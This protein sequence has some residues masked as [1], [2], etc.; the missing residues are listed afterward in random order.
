MTLCSATLVAVGSVNPNT[1]KSEILQSN[2][3]TEIEDV[4]AEG[5]FNQY[6]VVFYDGDYYYFGGDQN[7]VY[8]DIL[9]LDG[10][11]WTW[12]TVGQLNTPRNGHGVILAGNT[13]KVIGGATYDGTALKNEVCIIQNQEFM[14]TEQSSELFYY[15]RY[16]IL[17]LV[18]KDYS[19][20]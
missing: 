13:F 1:K 2:Q 7:I 3:W 8:Q 10:N 12:S 9:R 20:C 14:C 5:F 19:N 11:R 6:A 4:P 16:P 18:N 17:H 15:Y